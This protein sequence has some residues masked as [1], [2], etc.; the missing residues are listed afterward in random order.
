M[1][2][3]SIGRPPARAHR[4]LFTDQRIQDR[5]RFFAPFHRLLQFFEWNAI[6]SLALPSA[7]AIVAVLIAVDDEKK[8]DLFYIPCLFIFAPVSLPR[9][10][11]SSVAVCFFGIV[12]FCLLLQK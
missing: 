5:V 2:D 12:Y 9:A 6:A 10:P 11:L 1:R 4:P 3:I 7:I 8:N